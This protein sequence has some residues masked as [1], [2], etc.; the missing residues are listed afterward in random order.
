MEGKKIAGERI[1]SY[2]AESMKSLLYMPHSSASCERTLSMVRKIVPENRT[3]SHSDTVCALLNCKLNCDRTA[4]GFKPSK[5]GLN[6]AKK[7]A[8]KYNQAHK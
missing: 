6:A 7:A 2:L 1:F 8:Y 4:A 5:V 3:S